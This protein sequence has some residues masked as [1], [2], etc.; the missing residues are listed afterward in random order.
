MDFTG[1][2]YCAYCGE[3][4]EIFV[5]PEGGDVQTV[6]E[7]CSVCCRPNVLNIR[8]INGQIYINS[9]FEG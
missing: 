6:T 4:N 2:Y 9:E 7:D 3:G 5:E 1:T 8:L